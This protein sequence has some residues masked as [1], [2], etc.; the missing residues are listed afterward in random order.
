MIFNLPLWVLFVS[1]NL[2]RRQC[3]LCLIQQFFWYVCRSQ[4]QVF[5]RVLLTQQER[6]KSFTLRDLHIYYLV[7]TYFCDFFVLLNF[8]LNMICTKILPMHVSMYAELYY[9][10]LVIHRFRIHF[11]T[12]QD[13]H[14]MKVQSTLCQMVFCSQKAIHFQVLRCLHCIEVIHFKWKPFM[15]TRMKCLL[16]Y[17]LKSAILRYVGHL[18]VPRSCQFFV[19]LIGNV[20]KEF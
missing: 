20:S 14:L 17:R 13:F 9:L 5:V 2:P 8:D 11:H 7:W 19:E 1:N 15:L 16:V 12:P 3:L 4:V 18:F 10:N 6:R